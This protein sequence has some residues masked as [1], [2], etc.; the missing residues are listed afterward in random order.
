[1]SKFSRGASAWKEHRIAD[2]LTLDGVEY[3]V[4]LVARRGTG[5]AGY[6]VTLHFIPHDSG[7]E[8]QVEL[9]NAASTADVHRVARE[10]SEHLD[11]VT[12][13]FVTARKP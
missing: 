11:Q 4:Q 9:E 2:A 13:L 8:V 3:T 6:R 10:L 7:E 12:Q 5:F 1:M